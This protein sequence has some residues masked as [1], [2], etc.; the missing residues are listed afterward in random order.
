[1]SRRVG[2]GD[3]EG[4]RRLW[5]DAY[6]PVGLRELPTW[7]SDWAVALRELPYVTQVRAAT[8][9]FGDTM[10]QVRLS[11][12]FPLGSAEVVEADIEALWGDNLAQNLRSYHAFVPKGDGLEF[13]F[14]CL[15]G[16]DR[17]LT[18]VVSVT[19]V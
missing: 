1:M 11:S 18:G 2:A 17:L 5:R 12:R 13:L 19:R 15:T 7:A 9:S 3:F 16:Q 8:E 4:T 10:V 6:E 14:I